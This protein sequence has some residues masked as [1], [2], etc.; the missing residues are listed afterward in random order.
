MPER[1]LVLFAQPATA[2]KEKK[3][4]GSPKFYKPTFDRQKVRISPQFAVLQRAFENGNV[5]E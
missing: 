1:P 3:R 5:R 4:G 2:D